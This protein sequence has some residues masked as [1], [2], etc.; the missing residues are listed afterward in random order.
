MEVE[1]LDRR[2][3]DPRDARAVA[4]LVC[5][6][7]P[8]PGRTVEVRLAEILEAWKGYDGPEAEHPRLFVIRCNAR[9]EIDGSGIIACASIAPRTLEAL[10]GPLTIMC[11]ARVCS[12]PAYRGQGLGDAVVRA[13]FDLV[14]RGPFPFALF[15]TNERVRPFYER[16]GAV[17]A[18][19]SFFNSFADDPTANP[20][21]DQVVM[22][23]PAKPGWPKGPI[24]L[25]GPGW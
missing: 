4:E 23:Y 1:S 14:D 6:V 8:K 5:V 7:W 16:Y 17:V 25:R 18:D 15:Q 2:D 24:D 20:F 19:N 22:R 3:L 11:L 10:E 12:D 21:W 9:K 13:A